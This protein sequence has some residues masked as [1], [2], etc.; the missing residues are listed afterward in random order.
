MKKSIALLTMIQWLELFL[1]L[2]SS[3]SG[4]ASEVEVWQKVAISY[5]YE[6]KSYL[7]C[8]LSIKIHKYMQ[9][10]IFLGVTIALWRSATEYKSLSTFFQTDI[11]KYITSRSFIRRLWIWCFFSVEKLSFDAKTKVLN[12]S[13][14]IFWISWARNFLYKL[15]KHII[16]CRISFSTKRPIYFSL[17]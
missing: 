12:F 9:Q 7:E 2:F 17:S 1:V 11:S 3:S 16:R 8:Y 5:F 15:R 4:P 14:T 10:I 6:W 13:K